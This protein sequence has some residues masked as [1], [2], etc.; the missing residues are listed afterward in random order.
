MW[1]VR[2]VVQVLLRDALFC[3]SWRSVSV[4]TAE[5]VGA[6]FYPIIALLVKNPK[7]SEF[8]KSMVTRLRK[9]ASDRI[10]LGS[11]ADDA[12]KMGRLFIT[13]CKV[14]S[15]SVHVFAHFFHSMRTN[16]GGDVRGS[17]L[18]SGSRS[19]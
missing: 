1:C 16:G 11:G 5:R 6:K 17:A 9:K 7:K 8:Y 4:A 15:Y 2:A 19:W 18:D 3:F 13:G 14:F 10:F 12:Q